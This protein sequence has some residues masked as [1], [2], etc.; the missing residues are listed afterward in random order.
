MLSLVIA[1]AFAQ[2]HAKCISNFVYAFGNFFLDVQEAI[3]TEREIE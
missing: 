2:K 3:Y 1:S